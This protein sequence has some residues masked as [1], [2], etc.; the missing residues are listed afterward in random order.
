M[1]TTIRLRR[2][3]SSFL[4]VDVID[5]KLQHCK[6]TD[7]PKNAHGRITH[8]VLAVQDQLPN[9]SAYDW[10]RLNENLVA[11]GAGGAVSVIALHTEPGKPRTVRSWSHKYTRLCNS[12]SW[13]SGSQLACALDRGRQEGGLVIYDLQSHSLGPDPLMTLAQGETIASTRFVPGDDNVL[14]AGTT[15]KGLRTHDLRGVWQRNETMDYADTYDRGFSSKP[16]GDDKEVSLP[17][18]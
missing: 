13:T 7:V 10:C 11:I 2:D 18:I 5:N 6:V 16:Y 9:F 1:Q 3:G 4:V 12:I 8:D 15:S 17:S 14:L